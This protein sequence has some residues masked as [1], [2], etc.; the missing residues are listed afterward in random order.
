LRRE[1]DKYLSIR[2]GNGLGL[3]DSLDHR[4]AAARLGLDAPGLRAREQFVDWIA[5]LSIA[6]V[7]G[8]MDL[9]R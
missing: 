3:P 1:G 9:G 4:F 8:K 2:W 6:D 7:R 5:P